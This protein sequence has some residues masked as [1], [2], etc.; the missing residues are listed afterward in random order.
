M[1]IRHPLLA[2]EADRIEFPQVIPYDSSSEVDISDNVMYCIDPTYVP[3]T[4]PKDQGPYGLG[5]WGF[6]S[7]SRNTATSGPTLNMTEENN[8]CEKLDGGQDTKDIVDLLL[9]QWT[10]PGS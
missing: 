7:A 4:I 9:E 1:M 6:T 2:A 3:P 10:V 5:E 8:S